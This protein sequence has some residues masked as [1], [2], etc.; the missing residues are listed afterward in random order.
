MLLV[1]A[2]EALAVIS[3]LYSSVYSIGFCWVDLL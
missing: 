2:D 1:L 3:W